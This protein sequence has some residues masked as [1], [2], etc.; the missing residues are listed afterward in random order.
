MV[1]LYNFAVVD[2]LL[3]IGEEI[4]VGLIGVFAKAE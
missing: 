4:A 2:F 1:D 3:Y